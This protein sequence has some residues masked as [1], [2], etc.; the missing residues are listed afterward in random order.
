VTLGQSFTVG[1]AGTLVAVVV[2]VNPYAPQTTTA[3]T[4]SVFAV[5][6]AGLPTGAA[7]A[8]VSTTLG[9]GS[10]GLVFPSPLAVTVGEKL[11]VSFSWDAAESLEWRGTC[12]ASAYT[13]GEALMN[14]GSGW[15]TF[16]SYVISNELSPQTYCLQDF[17]FATY[18][19]AAPDPTPSPTTAPTAT[20][21]VTAPPTTQP[22]ATPRVTAPPTSTTQPAD[23]SGSNVALLVV[24]AF[25]ALGAAFVAVRRGA[26]TRR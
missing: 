3:A 22:T 10:A 18:V 1:H 17:T 23:D 19:L 14:T 9:N 20:A 26:N 24:A 8:S 2:D 15:Q 21:V 12:N 6:G 4:L 5:D 7:L 13:A 16:A 25:F 11:A